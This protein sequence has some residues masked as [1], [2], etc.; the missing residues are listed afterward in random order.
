M[1]L[2]SHR[3]KFVYIHIPKTGGTAI[4]EAIRQH[5]DYEFR[6]HNTFGDA[7]RQGICCP[8]YTWIAF[9]RNPWDRLVSWY[10]FY[11]QCESDPNHNTCKNMSFEEWL[12]WRYPEYDQTE[13]FRSEYPVKTEIG[14]FESFGYWFNAIFGLRINA[15]EVP[16]VM[17]QTVHKHYSAYYSDDI[18][19]S[20]IVK[21][22]CERDAVSFGYRFEREQ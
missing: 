18:L 11:R 9:V 5:T 12:E 21:H 14:R 2:V 6:Q 20:R 8:G 19:Q 17:N 16:K 1:G 7:Q 10:E 15:L 3:Y 13:Y 4:R 22:F